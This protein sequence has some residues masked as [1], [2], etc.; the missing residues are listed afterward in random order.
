ML[1][2][3]YMAY[4][5]PTKFNFRCDRQNN[6]RENAIEFAFVENIIFF[7]FGSNILENIVFY[8]IFFGLTKQTQR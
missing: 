3:A 1:I 8:F 7:E 6:N 4:A 2:I 5:T